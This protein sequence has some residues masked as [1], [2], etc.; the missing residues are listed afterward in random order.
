MS[1]NEGYMNDVKVKLIEKI[2]ASHV[3]LTASK[4]HADWKL[5]VWKLAQSAMPAVTVRIMPSVSKDIAYGRQVSKTQKGL[6]VIYSFSAHIWAVRASGSVK[7]ESAQ[8][9]ADAIE[10]YLLQN[11]QDTTTG[12]VYVFDITKRESQPERGAK[13]YQRIIMN[14]KILARKPF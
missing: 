4:V 8:D 10:T 6:Y 12:I 11:A 13:R 14:G 5:N 2:V 7:A 9:L 1:A 3:D